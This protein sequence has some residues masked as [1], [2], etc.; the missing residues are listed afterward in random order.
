MSKLIMDNGKPFKTEALAWKYIEDK[1][2]G[3]GE[4]LDLG[5]DYVIQQVVVPKEA[6]MKYFECQIAA[7]LSENEDVMIDLCC[8]GLQVKIRR[9]T[10][11]ILPEKLILV[12]E[13]AIVE[14][15]ELKGSVLVAL[16]PVSACPLSRLG[17]STKEAYDKQV[18]E[19]NA[20][21][22]REIKEFNAIGRG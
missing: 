4:V 2:E 20:T 13:T 1:L 22:D 12:A 3:K 5:D 9:G 10:K 14:K 6:P 8:N 19:G 17:P 18:K 11:V 7:R 16:G 15:F 21:R